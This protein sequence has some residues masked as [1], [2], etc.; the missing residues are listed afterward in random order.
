MLYPAAVA[1]AVALT[2][3]FS[4]DERGANFV[5]I[6]PRSDIENQPLPFR[7]A[8]PLWA[9]AVPLWALGDLELFIL[10]IHS[11]NRSTSSL[12]VS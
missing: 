6:T 5:R 2:P 1:V 9:L 3:V 12:T 10:V 11:M 8:V 7:T 4:G